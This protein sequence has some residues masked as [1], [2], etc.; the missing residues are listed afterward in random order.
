MLTRTEHRVGFNFMYNEVNWNTFFCV[1]NSL[2][3]TKQNTF[4]TTS[5][6]VGYVI[7]RKSISTVSLD[8][9]QGTKSGIEYHI[10]YLV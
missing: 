3:Y 5:L 4:H 1:G 10:I 7:T 2:D 8:K 9:T 6:L